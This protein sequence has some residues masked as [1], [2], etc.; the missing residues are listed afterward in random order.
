MFAQLDPN[1][2]QVILQLGALGIL[3]ALILVIYPKLTRESSEE[4][5]K[6]D[7]QHAETIEKLQEKFDE[8]NRALVDAVE[9]QTERLI[10][11]MKGRNEK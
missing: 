4:R 9:R 10:A 7:K 8:R 2:L 5:A 11:E 1:W 3:A 6:R